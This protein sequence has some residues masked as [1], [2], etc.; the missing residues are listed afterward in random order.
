[1]NYHSI[2][3]AV[4][5]IAVRTEVAFSKEWK[6]IPIIDN[7]E[8][9]ILIPEN[10]CYPFYANN[11]GITQDKRIFLRETLFSMFMKAYEYLKCLGLELKIYDGWRPVYLQEHLYWLYMKKFTIMKFKELAYLFA[12]CSS[13]EEFKDKFASLSRDKQEALHNI[14]KAYVSWPSNSYIFPSPHATGG[15]IDVWLFKDGSSIDLGIEFDSME[16]SAG[17]F[18]HLIT[19]RKTFQNDESIVYYRNMLLY[20]MC[21]AGFSCYPPEIWHFNYGNQMH[22]LVAGGKACYSYIEP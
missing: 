6:S 10:F 11:M 19:D 18:Y 4:E 8:R 5:K 7:G 2:V 17:A 9:L 12:K 22:A 21:H 3:E 14:N 1:M 20:A 13:I 16:Q 15:A